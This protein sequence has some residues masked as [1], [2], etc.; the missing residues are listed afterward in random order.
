[1]AG[2]PRVEGGG[3]RPGWLKREIETKDPQPSDFVVASYTGVKKATKAG[4]SDGNMYRL[5]VEHNPAG[6]VAPVSPEPEQTEDGGEHPFDDHPGVDGGVL[7]NDGW[8]EES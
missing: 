6:R 4:Y 3:H 7:D 8:A 2:Q 5:F 1:M